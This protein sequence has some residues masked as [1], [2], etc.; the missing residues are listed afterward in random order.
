VPGAA[1]AGTLAV[2][3]PP[4]SVAFGGA[5][6]Y[7]PDGTTVAAASVGA[8]ALTSSGASASAT[9][10]SDVTSLSL[11]GGEI[12]AAKVSARAAAKAGPATAA[13]GNGGSLVSKLVVLGQSVSA[14]AGTQVPV[15]DWG[16]LSVLV[17]TA[18]PASGPGGRAYRATVSGLALRL[19]TAHAGLPAG[20][21]IVVGDVAA[22]ARAPVWPL[23][24]ARPPAPHPAPRPPPRPPVV[25]PTPPPAPQAPVTTRSHET[26]PRT[27]AKPTR[28][29]HEH[30][31][32]RSGAAPRSAVHRSRPKRR[33]RRGPTLPLRATPPLGSGDYVFPVFGDASFGDT[34]GAARAD[35]SYHHGDDIFARRGTPVLAVAD[36]TVFSV[37]FIP[38]GGNRLW[39]RD[40]HGNQFYYA[41][42]AAYA[43]LG[44][45]GAR[46]HAGDVLGFVGDTGDARGT[47]FHLHFEV[48]PRRYLG[49][50]YDGAVDPTGY[51][52]G[53]R[54][55][56]ALAP[57]AAAFPR[58]AAR[59]AGGRLPEPGAILLHV[60]D[61][62]SADGLEPGSLRTA[63][64]ALEGAPLGRRSAKRGARPR[65]VP[66]ARG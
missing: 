32:A 40:G 4:D 46:V 50:G 21:R 55:P 33:R 57:G 51:L 48:H 56:R 9:A 49:L 34:F 58:V 25:T 59:S 52:E 44:V 45:N 26:H 14:A 22:A 16:T 29:A 62:S 10:S 19:T 38:I 53:W 47:P 18:A 2:A 43:P 5:F 15:A 39:L 13:G 23:A 27:R 12:T 28:H 30:A 63:L 20:T 65:T 6:A 31:K 11:F 1:P 35:V 64:D 61:I 66:L 7:G 54:R 17:E 8:S 41:H 60:A 24:P 37:G 3:A 36:G 42:L